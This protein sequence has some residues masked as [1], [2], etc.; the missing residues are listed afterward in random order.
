MR[1]RILAAGMISALAGSLA[2]QAEPVTAE[3]FAK[4]PSVSSVSMSLEGDM[5]V[6]VIAD[7]SKDGDAR[8]AA[9]WD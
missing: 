8:A 4:F 9:Y 5:L 3:D 1:Y 2:A 6:G 7:P